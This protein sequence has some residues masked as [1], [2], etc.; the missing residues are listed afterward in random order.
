MKWY[1][2]N[3][4]FKS[5]GRRFPRCGRLRVTDHTAGESNGLYGMPFSVPLPTPTIFLTA[6]FFA[7]SAF[8]GTDPAGVPDFHGVSNFHKVNDRIFRGGQPSEEGFKSLSQLGVKT[9]IDLRETGSR[10]VAEKQVV[11][12]LG[13]HYISVPMRGMHTPT[14]QQVAKVLAVFNDQAAG[15]VFVH[16]RQGMDRTG[17]V[18]ACYRITHD[19]WDNSKA[20]QEAKSLGMHWLQVAMKNY[21]MAFHVNNLTP[22]APVLAPA[23]SLP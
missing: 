13:M 11:E 19:H 1:A 5:A 14:D 21:V 2:P 8:A 10:S 9:V 6:L 23:V 12:S 17:T 16:C 7:A 15:P 18:V 4:S 3:F 20:L 22:P